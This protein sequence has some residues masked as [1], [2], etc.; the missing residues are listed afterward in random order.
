M[1]GQ[2]GAWGG[3]SVPEG[4]EFEGKTPVASYQ[5]LKVNTVN[6]L[7]V[8]NVIIRG[9]SQ[10]AACGRYLYG[11]V[12]FCSTGEEVGLVIFEKDKNSDIISTLK[13]GDVYAIYNPK[14][15]IYCGGH[16]RLKIKENT[17]FVWVGKGSPIQPSVTRSARPAPRRN[18]ADLSASSSGV[19]KQKRSASSNKKPGAIARYKLART[20]SRAS[21][22]SSGGFDSDNDDTIGAIP[23]RDEDATTVLTQIAASA[24]SSQPQQQVRRRRYRFAVTTAD[25]N[26]LMNVLQQSYQGEW[27]PA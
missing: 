20:S 14:V 1:A 6:Q 2:G 12:T 17:S 8:G 5:D 19:A 16:L 18:A 25:L 27:K 10:G 7:I 13:S 24:A 11:G 21:A 4:R 15:E 22:S 26:P 23:I 3:Y 9:D